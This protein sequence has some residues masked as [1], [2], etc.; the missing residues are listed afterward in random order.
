[1]AA[2]VKGVDYAWGRPDPHQ[3]YA[4]GYRFV[5]RY[6]SHDQGKSLSR[7][8]AETL[9]GAG[10]S[11]ILN[12][13]DGAQNALG[14]S[15]QGILDGAFACQV[16][17]SV[18]APH[19]TTIFYSVDFEMVGTSQED[20][21]RQ[22]FAGVQ[23]ISAQYGYRV[24]VYGG[25]GTVEALPKIQAWQTLAWSRSIW[26]RSDAVQQTAINQT[27]AGAAVD[28]D[29]APTW[30]IPGAWNP[31]T[32]SISGGDAVSRPDVEQALNE[33]TPKG[34]QNWADGNKALVADV[35][36]LVNRFDE[37]QALVAK[38]AAK[39]GA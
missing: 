31:P 36:G 19:T 24:G 38:I 4:E 39:I 7:A 20:A 5:C 13:E 8:E 1:M 29:E 10:L 33:G 11:I 9:I 3:L 25:L 12:F 16:A 30:P 2:P 26:L 14:G 18:R 23:Q 34:A 32:I 21:I 37:L 6:L 28:L 22:Y 17:L 27:V 35:Q 15:K